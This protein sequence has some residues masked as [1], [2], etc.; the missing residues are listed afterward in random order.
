MT[1]TAKEYKD[2]NKATTL[3]KTAMFAVAQE[4]QEELQTITTEQLAQPISDVLS[5]GALAELAYVTSQG[6]NAIATA[7][8]NKGVSTTASETLIQMAD[9]IN[10][11]HIVDDTTDITGYH[12]NSDSLPSSVAV[13]ANY[14]KINK[15]PLT[16]DSIVNV[17]TKL[18]YIPDGEYGSFSEFIAGATHTYDLAADDISYTGDRSNNIFCVSEDFSKLMI[19]VN[20]SNLHFIFTVSS[21]SGFTKTKEFTKNFGVKDV[22]NTGVSISD[23]ASFVIYYKDYAVLA[24]YYISSETETDINIPYSS[25]GSYLF[26]SLIKPNAIYFVIGGTSN[27]DYFDAFSIAYTKSSSSEIQ[28]GEITQTLDFYRSYAI[29]GNGDWLHIPGQSDTPVLLFRYGSMSS[30]PTRYA[31]DNHAL[32][33]YTYTRVKLMTS[34][35]EEHYLTHQLCMSNSNT[36]CMNVLCLPGV[37]T[38]TYDDNNFYIKF[39]FVVGTYTINRNTGE[40]TNPDTVYTTA[41]WVLASQLGSG[42][43]ICCSKNKLVVANGTNSGQNV[44][45]STVYELPFS[46]KDDEYI[47]CKIRKIND[48]TGYYDPYIS[49]DLL[50]SGAYNKNTTITPTVPDDEQGGGQ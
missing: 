14:P 5:E 24:A 9:K 13:G 22:R 23:D 30:I 27:T 40:V 10:D 49:Y 48:K 26:N 37:Y 39:P 47:Y 6:K 7:L 50:T 41:T 15:H 21:D 17:G 28:I 43:T 18:Y 12:Y 2:L 8:T 1:T 19:Q 38:L 4:G 44:F 16:G 32:S 31:G 33:Y 36:R 20:D 35:S 25:L 34:T 3:D 29:P 11:L 45:T 42:R 46:E